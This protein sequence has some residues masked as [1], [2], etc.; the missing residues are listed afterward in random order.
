MRAS[1]RTQTAMLSSPSRNHD[2]GSCPSSRAVAARLRSSS[3][4]AS[5][6][7]ISAS[8]TGRCRAANAP[9]P[10][11]LVATRILSLRAWARISARHYSGSTPSA[12]TTPA[13]AWPLP[14][15][16][17][18]MLAERDRIDQI[19]E[20]AGEAG[21]R[22]LAVNRHLG[23]VPAF[24]PLDV[25]DPVPVDRRRR[26]VGEAL[27]VDRDVEKQPLVHLAVQA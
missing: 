6:I 17:E 14:A 18:R 5:S 13:G 11:R 1:H 7:C 8:D 20:L 9:S 23:L 15:L 4:R 12:E 24:L 16:E 22:E 26:H 3:P 21:E 25:H 2:P 19:A 10:W 27:V